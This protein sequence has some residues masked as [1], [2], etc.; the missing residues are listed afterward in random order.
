MYAD[1]DK[2]ISAKKLCTENV[3]YLA[4]QMVEGAAYL[5]SRKIVHRDL[6]P[7]NVVI[8]WRSQLKICNFGSAMAIDMN[9]RTWTKPEE[10]DRVDGIF[11]LRYTAPE[12]TTQEQVI[13]FE[14]HVILSSDKKGVCL[15]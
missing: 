6:K 7:R 4:F 15:Y 14:L 9:N 5:H 1:L 2:L 13:K 10:I 12:V 3:R 8:N 11:S